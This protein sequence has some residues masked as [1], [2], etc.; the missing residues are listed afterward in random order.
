M[1]HIVFSG[2]LADMYPDGIRVEANSPAE[3]ISALALYPGFREE[4]NVKHT[5]KLP[6][7]ESRDAIFEGTKKEVIR[8][9]PVL[10]GS[11]GKAGSFLMIAIGAVLIATGWGAGFGVELIGFSISAGT[12]TS[13]GVT[14]IL[15]GVVGLL[16]PAPDASQS[17]D[18]E[19]SDYMPANRNTTRIGTRIALLFGRRRVWGHMLSFNVTAKGMPE[20]KVE[21]IEVPVDGFAVE[22]ATDTSVIPGGG[23]GD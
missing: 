12:L 10:A 1:K 11:G 14:L 5:V 20:P 6:D 13:I 22:V 2:Y 21:P 15:N 16:S 3:C 4:D 17:K 7:F 18:E 8:V 23:G 9:E 19:K